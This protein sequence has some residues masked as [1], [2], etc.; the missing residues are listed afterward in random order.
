M[1]PTRLFDPQARGKGRLEIDTCI[2]G[3]AATLVGQHPDGWFRLSCDEC[4]SVDC[5]PIG[6]ASAALLGMARLELAPE[7]L[8]DEGRA[9]LA[10]LVESEG[11][12]DGTD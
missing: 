2:C 12:D 8:S 3:S 9:F 1:A 11:G 7:D 4:R 5:T 10:Y 6:E